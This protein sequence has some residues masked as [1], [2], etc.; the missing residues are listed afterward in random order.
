MPVLS[1]IIVSYNTREITLECLKRIKAD[2]II[3]VDNASGDG[4][5]EAIAGKFPKVKIIKNRTNAGFAAANNQG[6]KMAKGDKILLLNSDCFVNPDTI[7]KMPDVDVV[8]CKLLNKDGSVQQSWGYFPSLRRITQ[9]MLF[10]DNLPVVR[11]YIDSIHVRDLSRYAH[12]QEVDWVTGAFVMLK[13]EVFEKVG[14]IDEKYFMYGEEMEW[15]YRIKQAGFAV[16]YSPTGSATHLLG[17]SSPN[18]APAVV[19]EMKGW[20]YWFAKHKSVWQQKLLPFVIAT[21]C[22]LRIVLKPAW[23]KHYKKAFSEIWKPV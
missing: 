23:S 8:G 12:E 6:M 19:G 4:T 20:I 9:M 21:G 5:V 16:W 1:V 10:L 18:R 3:V 7:A 22:L 11:K 15:M 2:E 14:G 17:A 13:R